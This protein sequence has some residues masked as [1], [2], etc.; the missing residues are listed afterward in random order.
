MRSSRALLA[1]ILGT[2]L[3][4]TAGAQ[5]ADALRWARAGTGYY[6]LQAGRSQFRLDLQFGAVEPTTMDRMLGRTRSQ[7]FQ[8]ALTGERGWASDL[9]LYGR[10]GALNSRGMGFGAGPGA[11]DGGISYGVG[12]SWD[13]S[14]RASAMVGWDSYD[15]RTAMGEREVRATSLGLQWRY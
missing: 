10:F 7:G 14:P 15:F 13:F 3:C 12:L 6:G 9:G 8:F 2:T 5:T 4:A 1:W 11:P